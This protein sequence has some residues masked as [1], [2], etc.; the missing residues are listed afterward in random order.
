[1]VRVP[2]PKLTHWCDG[3]PFHACVI[4]NRFALLS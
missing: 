2:Q 4:D 3:C 1:M